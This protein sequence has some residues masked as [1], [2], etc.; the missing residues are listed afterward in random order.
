MA[1][2]ESPPVSTQGSASRGRFVF[3]AATVFLASAV[4]LVLE[5]AAARLIAPYVG[6][7]LY[8]WT[9]VIGVILAGLSVGNW[10]GGVW[11]DRG[12]ADGAAGVSL[13]LSSIAALLVLLMLTL[14]APVIQ[15]S[16][17]SLLSA[18]F[19]FVACLFFLPALMLGIVTPLLT[20]LALKDD[21]RPGHVIGT[22]HAMAALG[23]IAGTFVTGYWLVQTFGTRNVILMAAALLALLAAPFLVRSHWRLLVLVML[24]AAAVVVATNARGGFDNPCYK[25]SQYYCI[26]VEDA[27]R[28]APFGQA[29][30]LVLDHLVHGTNHE[31]EPGMLLAPYAQLVDE[32]VLGYFGADAAHARFLFAGGGAYTLPRAVR[33]LAPQASVTVAEIDPLVTATAE[34]RLYVSTDGMRV[35][36]TDARVALQGLQGERFDVI[37][38]DVYQDLAVP[39]HLT[40][41]E[42]VALVKTRLAPEG[43]YLLNLIDVFPDPL[44]VKSIVKTLG[45]QFRQVHVWIE[46]PP[47]E[48]TRIT[49]LVSAT[50]GVEPPVRITAQRGFERR[51]VRVTDVLVATGT[52]MD[53]LPVLTD[54]F[55]PVERLVGRLLTTELGR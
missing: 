49:F 20:T 41:R 36:H 38:G 13:L 16:R 22:M 37:V 44:L 33:A 12:G 21:S 30:D 17:L 11:A 10:L 18:S 8:T 35:L 15:A 2:P 39:Y 28:D 4:L 43:L 40:T 46:E 54:D 27:S 19:L 32:L 50:D 9:S 42:F 6:V 7:S 1:E 31:T 45:E 47:A 14:V 24:P 52:P 26:R 23:S 5:I 25:E 51:W 3:Y 48:P 29:T 34:E 53:D 55:V